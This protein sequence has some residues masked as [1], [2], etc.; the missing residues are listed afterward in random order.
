[1]AVDGQTVLITGAAQ[2]IGRAY[3][4]RFAAAGAR[5]VIIDVD[6][7]QG[8]ATA[9]S[10]QEAGG[11]AEGIAADVSDEDAMAAAADWAVKRFGRIDTLINNA[12]LYGRL[13]FR[14]Q[15]IDYLSEVL[16][17]NLIGV[18]VASRAV[19]PFMREKRTGSIINIASTAAYE[20]VTEDGLE[21]EHETIPSFHYSLSKSGVVALTKFMAGTIGKYGI[22]V[23]C[24][25][26]GMTLSD[27][28]LRVL[29]A[30]LIEE[31]A[32]HAA[33]QSTLQPTDITGTAL[34]LASEDSRLVTGQVIMV[35]A[36][37]IMAG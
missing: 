27:T 8:A 19:F 2:G 35:D 17:V 29:P 10:I 4:E 1:M 7:E 5:V 11:I 20:F 32:R 22:R 13:K 37:Y 15:S 14:D 16:R 12:G 28:T 26:P 30:A 24:I 6:A 34:Y 3:A 25:C 18:L 21:R 33:M 31:H 23:N 36:G 9:R